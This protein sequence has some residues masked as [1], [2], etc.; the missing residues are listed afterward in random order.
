[1]YCPR[2]GQPVVQ[3]DVRCRRCGV[4]FWSPPRK[5][6]LKTAAMISAGVVL[7]AAALAMGP[8]HLMGRAATPKPG[9]VTASNGSPSESMLAQAASA[10][11]VVTLASWGKPTES[12]TAQKQEAPPSTLATTSEPAVVMASNN[13]P[14][15]TMSDAQATMPDNVR[16]WL[17]HLERTESSRN[18]LASS[19]LGEA[20][21]TLTSLQA[22]GGGANMKGLIEG[23]ED[24]IPDQRAARTGQCRDQNARLKG[25]WDSLQ[26]Q[27]L[28]VSAPSECVPIQRAYATALRETASMIVEVSNALAKSTD[29]PQAA[30]STLYAMQ[31]KSDNRIGKP[32]RT[33]DGLV[34]DVCQKYSTSKWF[35]IKDDFGSGLLGKGM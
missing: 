10:S 18:S 30:L 1:M 2:C 24:A 35:S 33:T 25:S 23:E 3:G 19:Q 9:N 27:F 7:F 17:E 32:C 12:V 13:A 15:S 16:K 34:N 29:D 8:G 31:G 20:M 6:G 4:P 5:S 21:S 22:T 26:R 11:P 28:A 14:T